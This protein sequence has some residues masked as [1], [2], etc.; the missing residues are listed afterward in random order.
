MDDDVQFDSDDE[1]SLSG[2]EAAPANLTSS[3]DFNQEES[4]SQSEEPIQLYLREINRSRLL[5]P[6]EEYQLAICVQ[7]EKNPET[8]YQA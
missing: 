5:Q 7:A 1:E 4:G 6:E 2:R 8:V 3:E